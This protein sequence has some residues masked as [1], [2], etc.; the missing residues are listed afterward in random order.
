MVFSV[1]RT[2][3]IRPCNILSVAVVGAGIA[4]PQGIAKEVEDAVPYGVVRQN[5]QERAP[6]SAGPGRPSRQ[7]LPRPVGNG[8]EQPP[9]AVQIQMDAVGGDHAAIV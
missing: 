9:V 7:M 2:G 4:R 8:A 1:G 5:T 3:D 6:P